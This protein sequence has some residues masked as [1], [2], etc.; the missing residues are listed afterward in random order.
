MV[1]VRLKL[2]SINS[3]YI[4]VR[5]AVQKLISH[6]IV[7]WVSIEK[8]NELVNPRMF[9]MHGTKVELELA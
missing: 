2:E 4:V 9:S 7:C 1:G 3:R 6:P 5:K 8:R